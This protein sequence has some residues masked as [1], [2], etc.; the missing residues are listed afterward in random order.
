MLLG[1]VYQR[2]EVMLYMLQREQLVHH[3]CFYCALSAAMVVG[4]AWVG[5][6]LLN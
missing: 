1:I 6:I 4:P 5:V 3:V 2:V